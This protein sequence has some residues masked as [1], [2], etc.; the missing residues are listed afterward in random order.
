MAAFKFAALLLVACPATGQAASLRS[1][2]R[3]AANPVRRVVSMLQSMQKKVEAE[4]EKEEEM[5][6]KFSCYCKTGAADL[7]A[8]ISAAG[9][10]GTQ[11]GS[12]LKAAEEQLSQVKQGLKE[13]QTE[14]A[15]AKTAVATA[16]SIRGRDA[17]KFAATKSELES[18]ISAI[19]QAVAALTKGMAGGFLQTTSASLLRNIVLTKGDAIQDDDREVLLSFLSGKGSSA[20][21]PQSG[22]VTGILKEMGDSFSKSLADA[23]DMEANAIKEFE[24]VVA[25][26]AKEID[27]LTLSVE[28]KTSKSG[29]LGVTIVQMK[30]D[31][32]ESETALLE[33]QKL[34][35]ELE[36]GCSTKD[37]DYEER[38]KTRHDELAAL[39]ETI[40]ILN[41]DD[42]LELFNPTLPVPSASLMQ[43]AVTTTSQRA[44]A[45]ALVQQAQLKSEADHARLGFL[46]LAL[47]GKKVGFE[48]VIKMID[49][50]VVL[51]KKEQADDAEKKE[52]CGSQFDSTEDKKKSLTR[53][54]SDLATAIASTKESISSAAED[55]SALETGIAALDKSVAE[56]TALRKGEHEEYK[57]L[58]AADGAA[59][60]LLLFARIGPARAADPKLYNPPA[61]VELSAQGAIERDMG[62]SAALVQVSERAQR[63]S[64]GAPPPETWSAYAKKSEESAGVIAMMDLLIS[65]LDKEMTEAETEEKDSQEDYDRTIAGAKDKRT[66]DSK[67]LTSKAAEKADLESDLQAAKDDSASTAKA[68]M[69][70]DKYLSQ[71]HAEC[72][73]L[74]HTVA[75]FDARKEARSGEIDALGKAKAVL[76]GADYSLL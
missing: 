16:T 20:Y 71:L 42:A 31:L 75:D 69:A 7:A 10:T 29:S 59:K 37:K 3:A 1:N 19:K 65:D 39:T 35:Q 25:A 30:N 15:E 58:M 43:V 57:A 34:L 53:E 36:S 47:R 44:R 55:I 18:Y 52:Y 33:D 76:S 14:R 61:K 51:L 24:A 9:T 32:S 54:A 22:E 62:S 27:A 11:L 60:E 45:V 48:V 49:D 23:S 5:Y 17:A 12:D 2:A 70:T 40:K 68:L 46:V 28:A 67:T 13:A 74:I 56:A 38:V 50:M 26:K 66:T 4:G 64:A 8:S 72:D 73:W 21:V 63:T 6:K 41:D